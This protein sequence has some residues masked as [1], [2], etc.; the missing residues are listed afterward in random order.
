MH[1]RGQRGKEL[2][3]PQTG[4]GGSLGQGPGLQDSP[5]LLADEREVTAE[6]PAPTRWEGRGKPMG[7][8]QVGVAA[9]SG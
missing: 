2:E 1:A 9:P 5:L 7:K 6:C 4:R 3:V 8:G